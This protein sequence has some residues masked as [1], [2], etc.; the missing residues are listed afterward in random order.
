MTTQQLDTLLTSADAAIYLRVS[1][2]TL[3]RWRCEG[4]GPPYLKPKPRIV[5][6]QQSA[7]DAWLNGNAAANAPEKA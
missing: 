1:T 3:Q 5:R 7:L 2:F 4:G 6:Y